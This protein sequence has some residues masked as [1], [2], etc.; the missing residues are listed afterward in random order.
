M[1]Y[2]LEVP[3]PP[4][5][6]GESR[7]PPMTHPVTSL[8]KNS[9]ITHR[10]VKE[11]QQTM[12][13]VEDAA[14][15]TDSP[16]EKGGDSIPEDHAKGNGES[17]KSNGVKAPQAVCPAFAWW[18]RLDTTN[19]YDNIKH[20]HAIAKG[21]AFNGRTYG[22]SNGTRVTFQYKEDDVQPDD[23]VALATILNDMKGEYEQYS[24]DC[25]KLEATEK[26]IGYGI[27]PKGGTFQDII[28]A[29]STFTKEQIAQ[30]KEAIDSISTVSRESV[31]QSF[32]AWADSRNLLVLI[33]DKYFGIVHNEEVKLKKPHHN[34]SGHSGYHYAQE[35]AGQV[36][37]LLRKASANGVSKR[38]VNKRVRL[39]D[40]SEGGRDKKRAKRSPCP[41]VLI[42]LTT[43]DDNVDAVVR[44][45][46]KTKTVSQSAAIKRV[47]KA[48]AVSPELLQA[49]VAAL[50]AAILQ[51]DGSS[52]SVRVFISASS[53][54]SQSLLC[55]CILLS[56]LLAK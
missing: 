5:N 23:V 7:A 2:S 39:N 50:G 9:L 37:K 56:C 11:Q 14:G 51:T 22:T 12:A 41:P 36:V 28:T 55:W 4:F 34:W 35:A 52:C 26:A 24:K 45:S 42:D 48:F 47:G 54:Y 31:R 46:Q 44:Q 10:K 40:G 1:R 8:A 20:Y 27:I 19:A 21:G 16:E 15:S 49:L 18:L 17:S 3:I 25:F 29:L 13:S 33:T 38:T 32:A 6:F 43:N 53:L 30:Y